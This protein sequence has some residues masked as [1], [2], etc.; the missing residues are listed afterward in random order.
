MSSLTKKTGAQHSEAEW[1][2]HKDTI[3]R[4]YI[5]DEAPLKDLLMEVQGLGICVTCAF[6][7]CSSALPKRLMEVADDDAH[8]GRH[9]WS[10]S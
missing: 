2:K 1:T 6:S 8:L 3:W 7:A 4:R 10:T 5:I 9:S